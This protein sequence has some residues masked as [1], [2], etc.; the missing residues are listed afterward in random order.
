[1]LSEGLV[2]TLPDELVYVV[3]HSHTLSFLQEKVP[4]PNRIILN[5]VILFMVMSVNLESCTENLI[6]AQ[7]QH[8][9]NCSE[10]GKTV[11]NTVFANK[12]QKF[13]Y[14][15]VWGIAKIR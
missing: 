10:P 11:E 6:P 7:L 3:V 1:M 4:S 12:C 13:I 2:V 9:T 15:N 8:T 5:N 14:V